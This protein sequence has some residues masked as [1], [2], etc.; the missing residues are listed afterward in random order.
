MGGY[1]FD[2]RPSSSV[3]L[4]TSDLFFLWWKV[5]YE[6]YTVTTALGGVPKHQLLATIFVITIGVARD[7]SFRN[8]RSPGVNAD[9]GD[10]QY[11]ASAKTFY[12]A[13][14]KR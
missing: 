2:I 3:L 13:Y 14:T 6:I 4:G 8:E 7:F 12:D 10:Q 11:A 5:I 9:R 1:R